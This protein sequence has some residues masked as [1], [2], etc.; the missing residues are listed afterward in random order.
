MKAKYKVKLSPKER[1]SLLTLVKNGKEK[2]K[3]ILHA[4]ILLQADTSKN[5]SARH[6]N[7]IAESLNINARIVHRVRN[8]FAEH[9]LNMALNR[10]EHK[11]HKPRIFDGDKEAR[12]VAICC[13]QAPEGRTSWTLNLL[14]QEVVKLNIVDNA[15]RST[16]H[17]VLKKT[18]LN[19]A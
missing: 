8:K 11:A 1:K 18:N 5:G 19:L 6:A 10:Q 7:H 9:G 4:Q 2:V 15:S 17:R 13:S 16:I 12:L 3:K 14:S